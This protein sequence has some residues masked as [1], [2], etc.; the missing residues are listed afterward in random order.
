MKN[1]NPIGSILWFNTLGYNIGHNSNFFL[2]FLRTIPYIKK[3]GFEFLFHC[4]WLVL[5]FNVQFM[6][7]ENMYV[8]FLGY[9][10]SW[11]PLSPRHVFF[12]NFDEWIEAK[13]C[14]NIHDCS[15]YMLYI[16]HN[17]RNFSPKRSLGSWQIGSILFLLVHHRL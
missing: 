7:S 8:D 13:S 1:L 12:A 10:S 4:N 6:N 11:I 17:F 9:N 2:N 16:W 14:W 15:P 5:Y 3:P